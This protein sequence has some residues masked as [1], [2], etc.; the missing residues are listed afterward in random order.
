MAV[1]ATALFFATPALATP[2]YLA[3]DERTTTWRAGDP[4]YYRASCSTA[5]AMLEI[6]RALSDELFMLK[7]I[8]GDCSYLVTPFPA[9]LV[10]WIAGPF[11]DPSDGFVGSVWEVFD[12]AQDTGFIWLQD[13]TGPHKSIQA[14]KA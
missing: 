10:E 12:F 7:V 9:V 6:I 14:R 3:V 5:A 4:V 2:D 13:T 1:L 11:T 8:S